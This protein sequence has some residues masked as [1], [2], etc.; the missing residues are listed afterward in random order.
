MKSTHSLILSIFCLLANIMVVAQTYKGE[1]AVSVSYG[2]ITGRQILNSL[3]AGSLAREDNYSV[4]YNQTGS[5]FLSYRYFISAQNAIG[6]TIGT[7]T[8]WG[9]YYRDASIAD[10]FTLQNSTI[11]AEFLHV[12]KIGPEIQ[13]YSIVGAGYS[14]YTRHDNYANI[15]LLKHYYLEPAHG[16]NLNFQY[17]PIAIMIGP[18]FSALSAFLELGIGYKGLFNFGLNCKFGQKKK[19]G[20]KSLNE[21]KQ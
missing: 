14:I 18:K 21:V 13:W 19:T 9:M 20:E 11:A 8:I 2:F 4:E 7:Q 3:V 17:T 10:S 5:A 12:Y 15:V 1:N 6:F 16:A